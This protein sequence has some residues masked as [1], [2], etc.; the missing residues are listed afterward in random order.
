MPVHLNPEMER[1]LYEL[2]AQT[3]RPA[4]E[5]VEDA[6][7]GYLDELNG[8]RDMLEQR[9]DDLESGRV[10]PMDGEEALA[11]LRDRSA[12]RRDRPA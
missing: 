8:V 5:L 12:R 10:Q 7:A 4:S 2:A 11:R 1:K 3:G 6:M 9:L